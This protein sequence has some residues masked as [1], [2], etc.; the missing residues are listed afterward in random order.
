M[1]CGAL[2]GFFKI[3]FGTKLLIL[4]FRL[5]LKVVN[6][7]TALLK[8]ALDSMAEVI[9][10]FRSI[11]FVRSSVVVLEVMLESASELESELIL[12]PSGGG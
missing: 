3:P 7:L 10:R 5:L 9:L 2:G 8:L 11:E 12:N 4:L 6:C 1:E